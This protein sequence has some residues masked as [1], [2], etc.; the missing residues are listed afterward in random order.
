MAITYTTTDKSSSFVK[1]L[2]YGRSGIGKTRLIKTAPKPIIISAESGLLSLAGSNIKAIEIE[3][4]EDLEDAFD[5]VK[6]KKGK[7]FETVCIDSITDIAETVLTERKKV[8]KDPRKAYGEMQEIMSEQIKKFRDLKNKHVYMTA[9]Q[10][11]PKDSDELICASMPGTTM[12]QNL[13]YLFDEV[14]ALR[15]FENDEGEERIV[16][17]TKIDFE[18]DCKDRSGALKKF[19][20][21]DLSKIFNKIKKGRK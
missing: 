11:L 9:K 4:V 21:L 19:E 16:L 14:F 6:G 8:A 20:S 13:P 18:Y 15:I 10:R 2:V 7:S 5:F 1:S 17:Q 12:T 3:T